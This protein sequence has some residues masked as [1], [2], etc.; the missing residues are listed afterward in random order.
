MKKFIMNS[1][2]WKKKKIV[3]VIAEKKQTVLGNLHKIWVYYGSHY[4]HAQFQPSGI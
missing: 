4:V 2:K 1:K 3:M